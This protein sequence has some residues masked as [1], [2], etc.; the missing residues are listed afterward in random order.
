MNGGVSVSV[1]VMEERNLE[2]EQ[3]S[4]MTML[5]EGAMRFKERAKEDGLPWSKA[6]TFHLVD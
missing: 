5:W 3:V 2:E 1:S 4:G 6:T